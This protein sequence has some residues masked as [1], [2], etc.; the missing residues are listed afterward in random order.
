MNFEKTVAEEIEQILTDYRNQSW[1]DPETGETYTVDT[2]QGSLVFIK[3]SVLGAVKWGLHRHQKWIKKQIFADE[4]DTENLEHWCWTRGIYRETGESNA[5]LLDRFL[6]DLQDPPAGGNEADYVRWAKEVDGVG[7]AWCVP[8]GNGAGTVDVLISADE[9]E[10]G[11]EEPTED[12][13]DEVHAYIDELNPAEMT[14]DDLR[15]FAPTIITQD[16]VMTIPGD[17]ADP[18]D[19]AADIEA[20]METMEPGQGLYLSKLT[21]FAINAGETSAAITTPAANVIPGQNQIIRPG[22]I[23]VSTA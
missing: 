11:S 17:E 20:F 6:A 12:L 4:A 7:S 13:L 5:D 10:T 16:V 3:A 21:S 14:E 8:C 9:E 22:D 18:D 19:V 23:D 1:I 2:S 15:V